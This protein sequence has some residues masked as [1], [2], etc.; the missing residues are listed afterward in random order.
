MAIII[1]VASACAS[2][3]GKAPKPATAIGGLQIVAAENFW[4]SLVSQLAG[5]HAQVMS[6][7]SDPNADPH[8]YSSSVVTARAVATA[9]YVVVNGAGYDTWCDKLLSAG[10]NPQRKI[11]N[12]ADILGL[13]AG[14]N[15]HFWYCPDYVNRVAAQMEQDLISIDPKNADGYRRQYQAVQAS[16]AQ[17]QNRIQALRQ[18]FK[19]TKVAATEDIFVYLG[20]A[21]GL[22]VI[23]PPAF[24]QAV[25][26]GI[27]PSVQSV[28]EFQNQI[29]SKQP[30]VL[31]YNE[32]TVTPLT[33]GMKKMAAQEN[34]PIVGITETVQ[35]PDASFAQW[36]DAEVAAL[37]NVLNSKATGK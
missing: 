14:G 15:P 37:Q 23:S 20:N 13:K 28:I 30:A 2:G 7:V 17:Y 27:D 16:L 1:A 31:V 9:D 32:Q 6:I 4:G 24:M 21:A 12:V 29:K 19:G 5:P 22:D 33:E 36:M 11:L 18:Q 34:I 26:E 35:P 10:G 8:E 3:C 25:A